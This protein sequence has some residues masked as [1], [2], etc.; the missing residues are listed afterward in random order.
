MLAWRGFG[1][2]EPRRGG[3]IIAQGKAAA[4]RAEASERRREAAALGKDPSPQPPFFSLR[5]GAPPARQTGVKKK[6]EIISCPQPRAAPRLP[7]A[8]IISSLW[9]FSLARS[10]RMEGERQ[11]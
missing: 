10:A 4:C 3:L 5:F 9:G 7:W 6:E 1:F 8:I 2:P 11:A